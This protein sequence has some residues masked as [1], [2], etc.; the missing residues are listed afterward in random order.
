MAKIVELAMAGIMTAAVAHP[1]SG[2]ATVD[3]LI[4]QSEMILRVTVKTIGSST[5]PASDPAK[6]TVITLDEVIAGPDLLKSF[7]GQDITVL[8]ASPGAVK[9][10]EQRILFA[11]SWTF[12]DS[13]GVV[14]V[15]SQTTTAQAADAK[16]LAEEMQRAKTTQNDQLLRA[17]LES[18]TLVVAGFVRAV[19]ARPV[20][21]AKEQTK[22]SEHDPQW[23]EAEIEVREVLKGSSTTNSI[24]IVFPASNDVMW[25]GAPRLSVGQ[26]G[27][28]LLSR[29]LEGL[30]AERLGV[31][32]TL[33]FLP[34][35][36]LAKVKSM[37]S[38]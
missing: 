27:V 2:Q 19:K 34:T 17:K 12:A 3:E 28:F 20:R 37:L 32:K 30:A 9:Q 22:L 14:E 8:L 24:S 21:S 18:A 1:T 13:I 6:L 26:D 35:S 23:T 7:K 36:E 4:R 33:D 31:S 10:G 15:G 29:G 5:V 16:G 38:R 11:N 25:I